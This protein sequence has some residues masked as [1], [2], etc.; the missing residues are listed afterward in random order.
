MLLSRQG[1]SGPSLA[2][3]NL[4]ESEAISKAFEGLCDHL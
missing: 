1:V 3:D 4:L 2:P